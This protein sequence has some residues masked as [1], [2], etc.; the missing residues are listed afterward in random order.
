MSICSC[1]RGRDGGS[2]RSKHSGPADGYSQHRNVKSAEEEA[3]SVALSLGRHIR[4]DV[5]HSEGIEI[6][7]FVSDASQEV[8]PKTLDPKPYTLNPKP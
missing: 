7:I 3:E 2:K 6:M 5:D 8:S 1:E 4:G